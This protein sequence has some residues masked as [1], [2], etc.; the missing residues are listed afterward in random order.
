MKVNPLQEISGLKIRVDSLKKSDLRHLLG[1]KTS[2][3]NTADA[4]KGTN[5]SL[6]SGGGP[7]DVCCCACACKEAESS[8]SSA[9]D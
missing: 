2:G 9:T 7:D 6:H 8:S 1:G 5:P 4:S 3:S